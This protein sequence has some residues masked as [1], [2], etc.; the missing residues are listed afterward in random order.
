MTNHNFL[1]GS[2]LI[3]ILIYSLLLALFISAAFI[4]LGG[5]LSSSNTA[6]ERNE[7]I[8]TKE[9]AERKLAWVFGRSSGILSPPV[10]SGTTSV[11]ISGSDANI[12]PT[13]FTVSGGTLMLALRDTSGTGQAGDKSPITNDRVKITNFTVSHFPSSQALGILRVN[14]ALQSRIYPSI[15]ATSTRFYTIR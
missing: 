11:W 1:R 2:T 3:E 12:Y 13:T 6:T 15:V 8:A 9:F 5:V 4:F 10:G 7:V 14:F